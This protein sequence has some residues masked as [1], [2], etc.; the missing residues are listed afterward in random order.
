MFAALKLQL[1]LLQSKK[2]F[3]L[4]LTLTDV[5][6]DIRC[7]G[8]GTLRNYND[9]IDKYQFYE[10]FTVTG[11]VIFVTACISSQVYQFSL[12][13]MFCLVKKK[14]KQLVE[15]RKSCFIFFQS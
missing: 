7:S 6:L 13:R 3:Y 2:L 11:R 10:V 5:F 8:G 15:V 12:V 4:N 9:Q 14:G 1:Q